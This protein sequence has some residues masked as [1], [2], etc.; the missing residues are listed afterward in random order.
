M[1]ST[2][3]IEDSANRFWLVR[4]TGVEGLDHV[5][6]GVEVRRTKTG[7]EPKKGARETLVRKAA[8]RI[9]SQEG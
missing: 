2:M 3:I 7:F 9:I 4:E 1:A 5:W 8:T 6:T